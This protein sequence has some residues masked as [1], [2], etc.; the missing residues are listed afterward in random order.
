MWQYLLLWFVPVVLIDN[1]GIVIA[2]AA[3]AAAAATMV[4]V[5]GNRVLSSNR[6]TGTL[7][8]SWV[9]MAALTRL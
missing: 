3:A 4:H 1:T 9:S 7:P 8:A 2:A 5:Y 6:L